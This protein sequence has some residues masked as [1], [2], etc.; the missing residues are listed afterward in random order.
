MSVPEG[1]YGL[2][3]TLNAN[4]TE[5]FCSTEPGIGF[6]ILAHDP[7]VYPQSRE[8]GRVIPI[9]HQ[10]RII[11]AASQ[12]QSEQNIRRIPIKSRG[13]LFQDENPLKVYR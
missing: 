1:N 2:K 8:Y 6:K 12:L 10:T 5:N 11:V 4:S 9:G 13:C 3:V 7:Q